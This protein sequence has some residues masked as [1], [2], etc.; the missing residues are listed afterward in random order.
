ME[1]P[2][3]SAPRV[4]DPHDRKKGGLP[5]YIPA[6][7][8]QW[9][10]L[11]ETHGAINETVNTIQLMRS[12]S[13]VTAQQFLSFHVLWHPRTRV[14]DIDGRHAPI[15]KADLKDMAKTFKKN[16]IIEPPTKSGVGQRLCST[17]P[18]RVFQRTWSTAGDG[19][20]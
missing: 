2:R 14:K 16:G 15:K 19:R 11:V 9:R 10:C 4:W 13:S 1:P 17:C 12:G 5:E 20:Y 7:E 3:P 8:S 18:P 6:D